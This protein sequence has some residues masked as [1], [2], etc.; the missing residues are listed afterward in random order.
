MSVQA[1]NVSLSETRFIQGKVVLRFEFDTRMKKWSLSKNTSRFPSKPHGFETQY[2]WSRR[3]T[4]IN[5]LFKY[6]YSY[7][8]IQAYEPINLLLFQTGQQQQTSFFC[9]FQCIQASN[10]LKGKQTI[11]VSFHVT[12]LTQFILIHSDSTFPMQSN[13]T[14][15]LSNKTPKTT[16]VS[17]LVAHFCVVHKQSVNDRSWQNWTCLEARSESNEKQAERLRVLDGQVVVS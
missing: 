15:V 6:F 3:P 4:L 12:F 14:S 11:P 7:S 5:V 1:R 2:L 8:D 17:N 16:T 9:F 10:E 13:L